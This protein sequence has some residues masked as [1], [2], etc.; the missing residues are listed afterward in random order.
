MIKASAIMH[1]IKTT[2]KIVAIMVVVLLGFAL[3]AAP[4]VHPREKIVN[5]THTRI[6][7]LTS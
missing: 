4:K 2:P 5:A 7:G 6:A 3:I 1:T